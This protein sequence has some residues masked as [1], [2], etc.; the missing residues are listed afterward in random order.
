MARSEELHISIFILPC[1][2][3][4]AKICSSQDNVPKYAS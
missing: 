4:T 2:P 1:S 3:S